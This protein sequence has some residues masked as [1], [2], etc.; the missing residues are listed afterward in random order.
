[1]LLHS[2]TLVTASAMQVYQGR[3]ALYKVDIDW[4]YPTPIT[5]THRVT[6]VV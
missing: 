5:T 1:M 2:L 6:G 3:L 4:A